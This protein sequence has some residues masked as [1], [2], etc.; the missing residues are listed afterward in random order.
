MPS[1]KTGFRPSSFT[2]CCLRLNGATCSPRHTEVT[3][4]VVGQLSLFCQHIEFRF[5]SHSV[6]QAGTQEQTLPKWSLPLWHYS[7][8]EICIHQTITLTVLSL[9]R[10]SK[11]ISLCRELVLWRGLASPVL[12]SRAHKEST[13]PRTVQLL[14]ICAS[15]NGLSRTEPCACKT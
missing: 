7:S 1:H 2:V 4:R 13:K 11:H 9:R 6:P 14:E 12:T 8:A 10:A 3:E 15:E 5:I